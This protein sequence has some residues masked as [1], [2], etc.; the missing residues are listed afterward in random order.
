MCVWSDK[1]EL[2][3]KCLKVG[4]RGGERQNNPLLTFPPL[5]SSLPADELFPFALCT[6]PNQVRQRDP[7]CCLRLVLSRYINLANKLPISFLEISKLG[8]QKGSSVELCTCIFCVT[9][10]STLTSTFAAFGRGIMMYEDFRNI[11]AGGEENVE[12]TK[13]ETLNVLLLIIIIIILPHWGPIDRVRIGLLVNE[14]ISAQLCLF[15]TVTKAELSWPPLST[16]PSQ[17]ST[18][19]ARQGSPLQ[20]R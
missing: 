3:L 8:P 12:A 9:T 4:R 2:P 15:Q 16:L 10:W 7:L 20:N 14:G 18:I 1:E 5:K 17:V 19:K 13:R 6:F 11:A